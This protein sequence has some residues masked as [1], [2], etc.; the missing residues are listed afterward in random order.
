MDLPQAFHIPIWDFRSYFCLWK[1][2][3]FGY[4]TF[5]VSLTRLESI[6]LKGVSEDAS[7]LDALRLICENTELL[8][9]TTLGLSFKD[10]TIMPKLDTIYREYV[11][12]M[13][14]GASRE[15]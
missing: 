5:R 1:S 4:S 2:A 3:T 8:P 10:F 9:H 6:Y 12:D 7:S 14:F 11:R 15:T 13:E